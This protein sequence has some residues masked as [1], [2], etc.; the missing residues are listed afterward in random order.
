MNLLAAQARQK[1]VEGIQ[2][3]TEFFNLMNIAD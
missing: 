1:P 2:K 3:E